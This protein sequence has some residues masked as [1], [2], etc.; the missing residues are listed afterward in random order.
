[1]KREARLCPNCL[2]RTIYFEGICFD[3]RSEKELHYWQTQQPTQLIKQ[4]AH[5]LEDDD[6][7]TALAVQ[8]N[9]P[10]PLQLAGVQQQFYEQE[11][12]Y[13]HA[14]DAIVNELIAQLFTT[15]QLDIGAAL[16]CC[17]AFTQHPKV[18]EAFARLETYQPLWITQLYITPSAYAQVAGWYSHH[19]TCKKLHYEDCYVFERKQTNTPIATIFTKAEG[20]C[21][22]CHS[23]LTMVLSIDNRQQQLPF[24]QQ[25][26]LNV[27]T[28]LQCVCY[29]EAIFNDYSLDGTTTIRPFQGETS[30]YTYEDDLSHA[31]Q[32]NIIPKPATFGLT[33][34]DLSFIGGLP[35]WVQDFHFPNCPHCQQPMT[36]LAQ[37]D[38]NILQAEGVIY[39]MICEEDRIT[40]CTYQQT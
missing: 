18:P 13:W 29:E 36:F 6:L 11:L 17:L 14:D 40:A 25:G 20:N 27:T 22:S 34:Y 37:A 2:E 30:P 35:H 16:L 7:L 9:I 31:Y 32:L 4:F 10:Y 1:M 21:P 8:G 26:W 12:L 19:G 24:L 33:P 23:P 15:T 5:Q 38:Q 39:M 28:C 3:C